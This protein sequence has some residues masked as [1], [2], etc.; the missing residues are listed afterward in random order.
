MF[1]FWDF[2]RPSLGNFKEKVGPWRISDRQRA[3]VD[4]LVAES[5]VVCRSASGVTS[6]PGSGR[7]LQRLRTLIDNFESQTRHT[8]DLSNDLVGL[9]E[10]GAL[11]VDPSRIAVCSPAGEVKPED[12]LTGEKRTEFVE[13]WR[14]VSPLAAEMPLPTFCYRA[15]ER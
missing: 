9:L 6:A 4:E 5:M 11:P 3:A 2:G 7:G 15:V 12:W 8:S 10:N 14:K 13:W 1:T